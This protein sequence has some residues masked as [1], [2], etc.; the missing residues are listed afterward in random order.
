MDELVN[1]DYA[2]LLGDIKTRIHSA[3]YAALKAVNKELIDLYWGIGGLIVERQ[4]E[5]AWGNS[6][7]E[8]LA[9]D[10]RAEFPGIQGFSAAN[11]WRMTAVLSR[12]TRITQNSHHW[13]E[14]LAGRTI[15]SF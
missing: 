2:A 6:V 10:I 5:A 1:G 11:L 8:R 4:Q 9:A 13:C 14:K 7:V 12:P 15:S 3:Q